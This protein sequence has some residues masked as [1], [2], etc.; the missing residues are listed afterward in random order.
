MTWKAYYP[1]VSELEESLASNL[2][3]MLVTSAAQTP[4]QPALVFFEHDEQLTYA[5]LSSHVRKVAGALKKVGVRKGTHVGLIMPNRLEFPVTWLALAWIG[6]VSVQLNPRYKSTEFSYALNDAD[7][8]F[9]IIDEMSVAPFQ[10]MTTR[11]DRLTDDNIF[12]TG[13]SR[14]YTHW[15]VLLESDPLPDEPPDNI[16]QHDKVA[17]LYTSG[18]TGFPK[19]CMLDHRYWLQIAS[20][21]LF[22]QG[23]HQPKNVLICEPMFY[24]QGNFIF[25]GALFANATVYCSAQPSIKR[26][27]DWVQRYQIDYC[28]FPAPAVAGIEEQPKEKG[29]SLKWVHTWYYHGD[30]LERLE[31]HFDVV[32]RDIYGMTENGGCLFVPVDRPDLAAAGSMGVLAPWRQARIVDEHGNDVPDGEIGEL[33]TTGPGH[34]HG[35]YRRPDANKTSFVGNWF[36]TGDLMRR[37]CSGAYFLIGRIKDMVKRSG[38]N[39]SAAE[40]EDCLCKLRGVLMAAVVPVPDERRGE[41]VKAYLQLEDGLTQEALPPALVLTHCEAHL[42]SFKIPRY[43]AYV[44]SFPLTAGNDKVSKPQLIAGIDDLRLGSYDRINDTWR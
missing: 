18:T 14:A 22:C 40:L 27:L 21:V 4:D 3:E 1:P 28:A 2:G 17:C 39:I 9:L 36:R 34:M 10:A 32:G 23:G 5:E 12:V 24:M 26:F 8:D 7:V 35:Y 13:K 29:Q 41:E 43:L 31:K 38:E 19:G 42:A 44:K 25:L 15:N 37:D 30:Q 6:A 20:L 11:P 16:T 33:W